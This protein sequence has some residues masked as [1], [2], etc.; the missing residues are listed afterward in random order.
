MRTIRA[1]A[2][3]VALLGIGPRSSSLASPIHKSGWPAAATPSLGAGLGERTS[4]LAID[5]ETLP[6]TVDPRWVLL[7]RWAGAE[8][9]GLD[10][11]L[12]DVPSP[13]DAADLTRLDLLEAAI[14][15]TSGP[16]W[17]ADDPDAGHRPP[18]PEPAEAADL[19]IPEPASIAL[20]LAGLIGL[21][22]RQKLQRRVKEPDLDPL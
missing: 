10:I 1:L 2:L 12:G 11:G 21:W 7:E 13:W 5:R 20:V 18:E 16:A 9:G 3:A 14:R 15:P 22:A 17:L 8:P 4:R 6:P 19:L